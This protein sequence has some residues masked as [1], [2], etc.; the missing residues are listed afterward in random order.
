MQIDGKQNAASNPKAKHSA[1]T[2]LLHLFLLLLNRRINKITACFSLPLYA[3][4]E[5]VLIL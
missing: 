1:P 3:G 4:D 2:P 5:N